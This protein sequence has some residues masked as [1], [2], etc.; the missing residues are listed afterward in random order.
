MSEQKQNNPLIWDLQDLMSRYGVTRSAISDWAIKNPEMK[1]YKGESLP[2]G[3]YNVLSSDLAYI[4]YLK[5]KLENV[6]SRT[7]KIE[8]ETEKLQE[9][10][11]LLKMERYEKTK[12]LVLFD[13]Y[14]ARLCDLLMVVRNNFLAM[15][16]SMALPL[17]GETSPKKI[18]STLTEAID[19]ILTHI[20]EELDRIAIERDVELVDFLKSR[21]PDIIKYFEEV[22]D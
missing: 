7:K 11:I 4:E 15:P 10:V 5:D 22:P 20:S 1:Q 12:K 6:G 13:E 18:A 14:C 9:Q 8:V 17:S 3:R 2:K 19:K 16:S 21:H